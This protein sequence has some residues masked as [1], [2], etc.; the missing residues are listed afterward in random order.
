MIKKTFHGGYYFNCEDKPREKVIESVLPP[1][2]VIPLKQGFGREVKPLVTVGDKVKA[3]QII[4]RDDHGVSSPVHASINGNVERITKLKYSTGPINAVIITADSNPD[5][6]PLAGNNRNWQLLSLEKIETLLYSSGA[7]SLDSKGIPTRFKT[8][9]N[10]GRDVSDLIIQGIEDRPYNLSLPALLAGE[11]CTHFIEGIKILQKIM[12]RANIHLAINRNRREIKR[13]LIQKTE[14]LKWLTFY[15]LPPRYPQGNDRV[16]AATILGK[17]DRKTVDAEGIAVLSVGTVLNVHDA[18]VEGK[19]V[20]ETIIALCGPG[21]KENIN[22]RVRVG[23]PIET[24]TGIYLDQTNSNWMII[25]N[26]PLTSG[27]LADFSLPVD[28]TITSLTAV[29]KN[30]K[31]QRP[32]SLLSAISPLKGRGCSPNIYDEVKP[33]I[34]CGYC[35]EI[36]PAGIIPHLIDKYARRNIISNELIRYGI[37]ECVECNLCSYICPSK[38]PVARHIKLGQQRLIEYGFT[39]PE[40]GLKEDTVEKYCLGQEG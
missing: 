17:R 19:P 3:G 28:R 24:I 18:V 40:A 29:S 5:W 23:T 12:P 36:C 25:P 33:C 13:E 22:I 34:F 1:M 16:L 37:F 10:V 32:W 2:V 35:E 39:E 4:G 7:T 31:V 21:W 8:S 6:Q 26:N 9:S 30:I 11:R 38:I 15:S 14:D 20:I 27:A